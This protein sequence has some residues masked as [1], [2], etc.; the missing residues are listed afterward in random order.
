[1]KCTSKAELR[2]IIRA[3]LLE[4]YQ[5]HEDESLILEKTLDQLAPLV[6]V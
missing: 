5:S 4:V 3:S 6:V 2:K 1:M